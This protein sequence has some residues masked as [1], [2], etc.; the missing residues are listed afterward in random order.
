MPVTRVVVIGAGIGGLTVGLALRRAGIE[1]SI[2]ERAAG[3]G[4]LQVGHGL[5][6]WP[7]STRLL[8]SVGALEAVERV[9]AVIE[10]MEFRDLRGRSIVSHPAGEVARDIGAPTL[11]LRRSELHRALFDVIGE[12]AVEFGAD[13]VEIDQDEDEVRA[14]FADGRTASGDVLV[15]ADGA[16]ST[17]RATLIG[18]APTPTGNVEMHGTVTTPQDVPSGVYRQ[19]WGPGAKFGFYP[20]RDGTCWYCTVKASDA[21]FVDGAGRKD[22]IRARVGT[23]PPPTLSLVDAESEHPI[24]RAVITTHDLSKPW[25]HGRV[26]LL[27]DSAHAMAPHLGQG[28]GQAIE[29][30]FVLAECLQADADHEAALRAYEERRKSHVGGIAK[31]ARILGKALVLENP[32]VHAVWRN[33]VRLTWPRIGSKEYVK[34]HRF[35]P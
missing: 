23:Y 25:V 24:T 18:D 5:T 31:Q 26:A 20:V 34:I 27:G 3:V 10:Q 11:G 22:A 21:R 16:H 32:F 12:D 28:A 8:A 33:A 1:A 13:C 4:E 17:I 9:G 30:A 7:N 29:D 15:A 14:R 2:Y 6:L 19:I 35:E